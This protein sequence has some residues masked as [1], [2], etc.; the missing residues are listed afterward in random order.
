MTEPLKGWDAVDP[1]ILREFD[2]EILRQ[3]IIEPPLVPISSI[4][5]EEPDGKE[6]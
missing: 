6:N 2:P 5:Q 4:P 3:L 1:N